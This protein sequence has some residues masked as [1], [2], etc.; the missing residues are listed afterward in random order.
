MQM[1]DEE[2]KKKVALF[3]WAGLAATSE[4]R[5]TAQAGEQLPV[6]HLSAQGMNASAQQSQLLRPHRL[7]PG[8]AP[9]TLVAGCSCRCP[10]RLP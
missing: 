6:R 3:P 7:P 5:P 10:T 2:E 9:I 1:A 4:L 8:S